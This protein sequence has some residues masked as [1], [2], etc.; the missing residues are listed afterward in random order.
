MLVLL[1]SRWYKYGEGQTKM[2]RFA[3][4]I[5]FIMLLLT[6]LCSCTGRD[7]TAV[8]CDDFE[9]Q[10]HVTQSI[11]IGLWHQLEIRLCSVPAKEFS[12]SETAQIDDTSILHQTDHKLEVLRNPSALLPIAAAN[13]VYFFRTDKKGA[14]IIKMVHHDPFNDDSQNNW[15][16]EINVTVK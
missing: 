4:V 10:A 6:C 13:E 3:P 7:F 14:T 5:C 9:K 8:D 15:T 2:K 16:Y 11:E 1:T 12:W